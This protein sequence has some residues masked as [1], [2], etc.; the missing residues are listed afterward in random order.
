M[1]I[2]TLIVLLTITCTTVF[3]QRY[4][5]NRADYPV[6]GNP[7]AV[8][9][10]DFNG[11]GRLD[12][13]VVNQ[14]DSTVQILLGRADGTFND[15]AVCPIGFNCDRVVYEVGNF[16]SSVAV[17]D[18]NRDGNSDLVVTNALSNSISILL[19][20]GDG[21]FQPPVSYSTGDFPWGVVIGDFNGDKKIDLA[22][23]NDQD[24]TVSIL[25]GNG[26]GT[27]QAHVDYP[28]GGLPY[29]IVTGDFNGDN[30]LDLAIANNRDN[31]V[32]I[33]LGN[34]DGTFQPKKDYPVPAGSFGLIAGDFNGDHK[35]DLATGSNGVSILIGNGDG[36]FQTA[37]NYPVGSAGC[38]ATADFNGDGKL[39][40]VASSFGNTIAVLLGNGDGTFRTGVRYGAGVGTYCV[41]TGDV[42][43]DGAIDVA[44]ANMFTNTISVLIGNGDGTFVRESSSQLEF[45]TKSVSAGDFTGSGKP[46]LA[47]AVAESQVDVLLNNAGTFQNYKA[48]PT[49]DDPVASVTADFNGDGRLDL[50]TY[51]GGTNL[52]SI[53]SGNGDGTFQTNVDYP[54]GLTGNIGIGSLA[55]GDFNGDGHPDLVVLNGNTIAVFLNNGNGTFQPATFPYGVATPISLGGMAV[56]DFNG[57]GKPDLALTATNSSNNTYWVIILLGNGDGTFNIANSYPTGY[58]PGSI[59]AA[60]LNGDGKLDLAIACQ[61]PFS[62]NLPGVASVLLGNGD[63]TFQLHVDYQLPANQFPGELAIADWNGDGAHDIGI[64]NLNA[65][66][67]ILLNTGSGTFLPSLD[68]VT[69]GGSNS[70]ATADFN[71]DSG[72]DLA[73]ANEI[74]GATKPN[75]LSVF[76]NSPVIGIFPN[77]LR[78][79]NQ[80]VGT[81]AAWAITLSNSGSATLSIS[82]IAV[83][84]AFTEGNN[85]GN[86]LP[87]GGICTLGVTFKP[88]EKGTYNGKLI[89]KD[90]ASTGQ[91]TVA[92]S[93]TGVQPIVKF[94]VTSLAFGNHRVGTT[95]VSK[96][97]TLT[98]TGNEALTIKNIAIT[99]AD[100]GDFS[101]TNNCGS[102]LLPGKSCTI[103]ANFRPKAKGTRIAAVSLNDNAGGSP[104]KVTLT[105]TGS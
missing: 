80:A 2:A 13:A 67:S 29:G 44:V 56:G 84:G 59:A 48:Y 53:L 93:G 101:Q 45:L 31:T 40:L 9:L 74:P 64:V 95:S 81:S 27:F 90:S 99:G 3:A 14:G 73:A 60:D 102:S 66:F 54:S 89:F 39:D 41:T 18:F 50:A 46:D 96:P 98:N 62:S 28:T 83:S 24:S 30:L 11:D 61:P 15:P 49:G 55:V 63:G 79:G 37:V 7:A 20:N 100:A 57:D 103:S 23:T 6:G 85:C 26:D 52:V 86:S 43:G 12:M 32:S 36:T 78:F 16:P 47:V 22:I 25:L 91:Q 94:S 1:R 92:L 97:V 82:S 38:V 58:N 34:G 70:I 10:A 75:T 87:P 72:F 8:A 19:G 88:T 51:D 42:N 4:V 69:P 77:V 76:L 65:G 35:L 105:G 17:G 104:Q 33:L 5:F 71:G 68:Y 21:T